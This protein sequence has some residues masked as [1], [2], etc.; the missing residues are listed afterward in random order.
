MSA[1]NINPYTITVARG[2]CTSLPIPV[3]REAGNSPSTVR[4]AINA[5][6]Q[7][8]IKTAPSYTPMNV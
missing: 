3:A 2:R 8:L 4:T 5:N 6:Y 7:C 1:E